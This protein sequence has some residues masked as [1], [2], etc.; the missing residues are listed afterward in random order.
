MSH[1]ALSLLFTGLAF[2]ALIVIVGVGIGMALARSGRAPRRSQVADMLQATAALEARYRDEHAKREQAE[3]E[4]R[5][6]QA[7]VANLNKRV[8]VIADLER[9]AEEYD[10]LELENA[11]MQR[12]FDRELGRLIDDAQ[13]RILRLEISK[14]ELEA[15]LRDVPG[16]RSYLTARRAALAVPPPTEE[17]HAPEHE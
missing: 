9:K 11:E 4:V 3:W 6:L 5:E 16:A 10:A 7:D 1:E 13:K 17:D 12:T 15:V 8:A 2:M 14:R